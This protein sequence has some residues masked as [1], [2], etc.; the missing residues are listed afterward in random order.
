MRKEM[1]EKFYKVSH[2]ELEELM[3]Y[4]VLVAAAELS[5]EYAAG[6]LVQWADEKDQI[7]ADMFEEIM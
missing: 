7:I 2:T 1:T 6:G 4:A 5:P 3:H